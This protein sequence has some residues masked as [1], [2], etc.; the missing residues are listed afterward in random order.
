MV[1]DI[2]VAQQ[3]SLLSLPIA[4]ARKA[5]EMSRSNKRLPHMHI[6]EK[7]GGRGPRKPRGA[8]FGLSREE[9]GF[10]D[11]R[12]GDKGRTGNGRKRSRG[13]SFSK[14][15]E[16]G[17]IKGSKPNVHAQTERSSSRKSGGASLYK[18]GNNKIERF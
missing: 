15:A 2:D 4:S 8:D 13:D 17:R 18:K 5:V 1:D 12:R 14:E 10:R 3:F 6:D 7:E 11:G 16:R 9:K